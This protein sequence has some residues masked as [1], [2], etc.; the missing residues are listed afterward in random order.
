MAFGNKACYQCGDNSH[1]AINCASQTRLC[2]NCKSADHES[3][4]CTEPKTTDSKQVSHPSLPLSIPLPFFFLKFILRTLILLTSRFSC[5]VTNALESGISRVIVLPSE[6][7]FFPYPLLAAMR[8]SLFDKKKL[9][10][11]SFRL[12]LDSKDNK[13]EPTRDLKSATHVVN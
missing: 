7:S 6:C 12:V 9:T 2:Y 3:N 10:Q 5:S 8:S 11:V 4:A 13:E 1:I